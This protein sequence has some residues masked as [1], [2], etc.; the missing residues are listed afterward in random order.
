MPKYAILINSLFSGGAE[1]VVSTLI[2]DFYKRGFEVTLICIEKNDFFPVPKDIKVIYLSE[3]KGNENGVLKFCS[4]FPLSYKLKKII[5]KEKIEVVQ[6]HVFR[7]NYINILAKLMGSNHT[8]QIVNAGRIGRYLEGGFEGKINAK[9][10]EYLYPKADL[11]ICKS[12]GMQ[13]EMRRF[14][15]FPVKQKVI[16]NPYD[17]KKIENLAKEEVDDFEFRKDKF[18]IVSVGRLIKPKRQDLI[19]EALSS[20][21]DRFELLL[22]GDGYARESFQKLAKDLNVDSR[23]HFIGKVKNPFKYISKCDLF[24][25]SSQSEGFPNVLV[26][27]MI[28]KVPVISTDCPSGPREILS[29]DSDVS[30]SLKDSIEIAPYG[31]LVPVNSKRFIK[32]AIE[33]IAA[34]EKLRK[35]L[36]LAGYERAISF[37]IE[38]ISGIY[39]KTILS[40]G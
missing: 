16:Y 40:E 29:P 18:Y 38:K 10:I 15:S 14:F 33:T 17:I 24:V 27:A 22:I 35:S 7:A 31:I 11:I 36:S 8:V 26:E 39:K 1:K 37:E 3:F 13:D 25:L 32:E 12:K 20:L 28:C 6:S 30:F 34:D 9:L 2:N 19:I 4:L 21:D 23:V 5:E